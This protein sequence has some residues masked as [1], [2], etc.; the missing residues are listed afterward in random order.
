MDDFICRKCGSEFSG[1]WFKYNP[2]I[3]PD[4]KG[5]VLTIEEFDDE[6][7]RIYESHV[8]WQI[9]EQREKR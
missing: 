3:C 9:E 4:C 1:L 8:E 5:P 7:M 6:A 2:R